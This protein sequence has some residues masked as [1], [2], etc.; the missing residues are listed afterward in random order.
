MFLTAY[1][2]DRTIVYDN[3]SYCGSIIHGQRHGR[4]ELTL[5]FK[6]EQLVIIAN[7][8]NN[9]PDT[10]CNLD[11]QLMNTIYNVKCNFSNNT[12]SFHIPKLSFIVV[13]IPM[14]YY[15]EH[16]LIDD[17]QYC[18]LVLGEE[19][20]IPSGKGMYHSIK[21]SF[22]STIYAQFSNGNI[23]TS[24]DVV[25]YY[26]NGDSYMGKA[27]LEFNKD[28]HGTVFYND[29]HIL[30]SFTADWID[31]LPSNNGKIIF[32][33]NSMYIGQIVYFNYFPNPNG[34]GVYLFPD[35]SP[36]KKL[37]SANFKCRSTSLEG[38][39]TFKN[40]SYYKGS[41]SFIDLVPKF[42]GKGIYYCNS[43]SPIKSIETFCWKKEDIDAIYKV[44]YKDG[45]I[46][47]GNL[48]W[49]ND[50]PVIQGYGSIVHSDNEYTGF[51]KN[52]MYNGN[53][54]LTYR[55]FDITYEGEFVNDLM[56]GHGTMNTFLKTLDGNKPVKITGIW[57]ENK[58][59]SNITIIYSNNKYINGIWS[60]LFSGSCSIFDIKTN[61]KIYEGFVE[62]LEPCKIGTKY[63]YDDVLNCDVEFRGNIE[64]NNESEVTVITP[65]VHFRGYLNDK[66]NYIG[67]GELTY[68]ATGQIIYGQINR[69]RPV[70]TIE[71]IKKTNLEEIIHH[72]KLGDLSTTKLD[73]GRTQIKYVSDSCTITFMGLI[74]EETSTLILEGEIIFSDPKYGECKY[75]GKSKDFKKHGFGTFFTR[76]DVIGDYNITANWE[77]DNTV[78]QVHISHLDIQF[79]GIIK[80]YTTLE[81]YG[82][83]DYG[84]GR[85]YIGKIK[86]LEKYGFGRFTDEC[87]GLMIT[88]NW[89][90]DK[91]NNYCRFF[92]KNTES[93]Y[94]YHYK[95]GVLLQYYGC[96]TS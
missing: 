23:D 24:K 29:S 84:S 59:Y 58:P 82:K 5:E 70:Q 22:I 56:E 19:N 16:L 89:R 18:G 65:D 78:G 57:S 31:D 96:C 61:K 15:V 20:P 12:L 25:I 46:Y 71:R 11:I 28:R 72:P 87:S 38:K 95:R 30:L 10:S 53:G 51:F 77:D 54:K 94:L 48:I 44:I 80:N 85:V 39:L 52:N 1:D 81:G 40:G 26:K 35:Y 32:S 63:F 36:Y 43:T 73:D 66:T 14:E 37:V 62:Q 42:D 55:D 49:K 2:Y 45:S 47:T 67:H 4:G 92:Y 3:G 21:N 33:N 76:N 34:Y 74:L 64:H 13:P 90:D 8:I 41:L 83:I 69:L 75:T 88:C 91:M 50:N 9:I 93:C 27:N 6:N 17:K 86:Q 7:W 79:S 60:D 68:L